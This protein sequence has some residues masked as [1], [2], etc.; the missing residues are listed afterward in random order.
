[1]DNTRQTCRQTTYQW[2]FPLYAIDQ[3]SLLELNLAG[4][5][6]VLIFRNG[7]LGEA[8]SDFSFLN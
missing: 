7:V 4:T 6:D 8:H 1:L 2:D 5:P 3:R